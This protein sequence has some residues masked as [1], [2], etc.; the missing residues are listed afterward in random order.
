LTTTRLG[1]VASFIRGITF[2]PDDVVPLGSPGTVG[3]MRT[4]NVQAELDL[5]DVWAVPRGLV[6]RDNQLLRCG[7]VLVSSANSWNLVGKCSWVPE[8]PYATSFGGFVAVLR[9]TSDKLDSRYLYRWFSS[10][11]IQ[12]LVRSFGR[13]TTNISNLDIQRCVDLRI[14][15]PP[16][17]E[18]RRIAAILD[19]AD[20]LRA[21]RREALA[22]LDILTQSIFVEMF[23]DPAAG[24][25][26][27][28]VTNLGK[29]CLRI[30]D[31]THQSPK[32]E[33]SGI[34]F[35]FISNIVQ[36]QISFDTNKYIS[37]ETYKELTR[38]C[39]IEVGDVLYTTVGS[40]GNVAVVSTS[41]KFAFQRH[42]AHIKP[43]RTKLDST[44]CAAMLRSPAI[45]RQVDRVARGVAQKTVNLSD[46]TSL[47]VFA[48][49][50][51]IQRQFARRADAI[52][53]AKAAHVASLA[54][55]N[56]L[57]DSL[58]HRGFTGQLS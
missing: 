1:E 10:P 39:P 12:T 35:I 14:P 43:D 21:K 28:P 2:K 3:C 33:T 27:M 24:R 57:F 34:P 22:Q 20:A 41:E 8:L 47:Q 19:Q 29:V 55:L 9:A 13:Q 15:L 30:T 49:P 11:R 25:S 52:D 53:S 46:L 45:R 48:P 37:E 50:M 23:G 17:P 38:R 51:Q 36:S 54:E 18:Q 26:S 58:Q 5:S 16:L 7:D 6:P 44:F 56:S 42:I 4:R 32:W 31:G 40:Y